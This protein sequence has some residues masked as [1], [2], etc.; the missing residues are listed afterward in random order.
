MLVEGGWGKELSPRQSVERFATVMI[1]YVTG[2]VEQET[3]GDMEGDEAQR[4][5][6][7]M[8]MTFRQ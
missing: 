8:K 4:L 5:H 6:S 3:E 1:K 2:Q 7:S